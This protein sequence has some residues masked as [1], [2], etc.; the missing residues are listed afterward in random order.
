MIAALMRLTVSVRLCRFGCASGIA[1]M[2]SGWRLSVGCFGGM[3]QTGALDIFQPL[4]GRADLQVRDVDARLDLELPHQGLAL[5]RHPQ[6]L[7]VDADLTR[8]HYQSVA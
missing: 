5:G 2:L 3:W 4:R 1:G 8:R 7:V 6:H